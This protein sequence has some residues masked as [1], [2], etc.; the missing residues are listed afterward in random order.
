MVIFIVVIVVLIFLAIILSAPEQNNINS[1]EKKSTEYNYIVKTNPMTE[2]EKKFCM[3]LKEI[4]DKYNLIIIPQ[5]Q[6]QRIFNTKKEDVTAFNKIK[7]KSIDFAIVDNNYNYKL[8]IEL[9]DYTHNYKNRVERDKFINDLF[10][11]YNLKLLRVKNN[12]DLEIIENTI[13]ESLSNLI[14]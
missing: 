14:S 6:L 13:K 5:L 10:N 9:D 2:T 3:K 7:S 1:N 8:F 12:Y 4:T 11:R